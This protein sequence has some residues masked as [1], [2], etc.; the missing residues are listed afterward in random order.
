M[1]IPVAKCHGTDNLFLAMGSR[2][3]LGGVRISYLLVHILSPAHTSRSAHD[4]WFNRRVYAKG[5]G[6]NL[7]RLLLRHVDSIMK[8]PDSRLAQ[9]L[10]ELCSYKT[11]TQV[12]F[13]NLIT[14][15]AGGTSPPFPF[16]TAHDYYVHASSHQVLDD[17]RIPFLTINADDDPV[18]KHVPVHVADNEWVIMVVTHG[19]G[20]M[21]WFEATGRKNRRWMSQPVLEWLRATAEKIDVPRRA[22]R[23]IEV[24]NGWLVENGREHL[25]CRHIGEGGR[26]EG[27]VRQK[28]IFAGL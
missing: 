15:H 2:D 22:T 28:G 17:V 4:H 5:M 6:E 23:Q 7:R 19:G 8:F 24:V 3:K 1:P 27:M 11:I 20:H 26:I 16:E 12:Q 9:C 25:G 21:G 18:V 13:D 10:P 14:I